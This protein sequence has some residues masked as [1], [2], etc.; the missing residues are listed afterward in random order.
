MYVII[1]TNAFVKEGEEKIVIGNFTKEE[2]ENERYDDCVIIGKNEE[3]IIKKDVLD[4]LKIDYLNDGES[5]TFK[6]VK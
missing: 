5:Y 6:Q 2:R 3:L 4:Y 1:G